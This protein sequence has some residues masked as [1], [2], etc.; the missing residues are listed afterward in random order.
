MLSCVMCIFACSFLPKYTS[1][2]FKKK[3]YVVGGV[4]KFY[5]WPLISDLTS[6]LTF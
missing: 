6:D 5:H 3:T 2:K 4:S 1:Y